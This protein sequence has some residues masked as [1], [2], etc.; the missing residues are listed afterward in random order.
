MN[1]SQS[2]D[3]MSYNVMY[4]MNAKEE[5]EWVDDTYEYLKE[6]IGHFTMLKGK[7]DFEVYCDDE[8]LLKNLTPN[9]G[10]DP[11]IED[12]TIIQVYRYGGLRGPAVLVNEKG[13]DLDELARL[14]QEEED[15][16]NEE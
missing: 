13:L 8:G 11:Y 4:V 1:I 3:K 15:K 5:F 7:G 10:I 14:K 16:W 12:D 9:G 2:K 6:K